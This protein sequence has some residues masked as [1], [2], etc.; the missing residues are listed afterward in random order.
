MSDQLQINIGADTKGLET[1]LQKAVTAIDNFD[2]EVQSSAKDLQKFSQYLPNIAVPPNTFKAA[3][4]GLKGLGSAV[5]AAGDKLKNLPSTTDK[6]KIALGNL[7]RVASDLPFGFIAISNNL[8]PLIQSIGQ[9]DASA[10]GKLG[11]TLKALG[12]ALAGPAGIA[13]AFSVVSSAIT[14]AVQKYGTLGNAINAIFGRQDA[15]VKQTQ[16][17][18]KSYEKFNQQLRTTEEIQGAAAGSTAGE[19]A[20]V[21]ALAKIVQDQ[22]KTYSERNTALKELQ[23]INKTYFGDI[24]LEKGKLDKLTTS[25]E[26]YTQATIQSAITKAFESE[27]GAT[28]V[29]LDRQQRV[30][31]KLRPAYEAT[32]AAIRGTSKALPGLA[33][34][35]EQFTLGNAA[36]TAGNAFKQQ[37][38]AVNAL[39]ERIKELNSGINSSVEAYNKLL[40]PQQAAAEAAKLKAEQD[41]K[42]ADAATKQA[43]AQGVVNTKLREYNDLVARQEKFKARLQTVDFVPPELP[44]IT[45]P[46]K[47]SA[48]VPQSTLDSFNA[49]AEEQRKALD[50]NTLQ[51]YAGIFSDTLAPAIDAA[52]GALANGTSAIDAIKNS[53]KGLLAQLAANAAKALLFKAALSFIPGLG[54]AGAIG[55]GGI[56]QSLL[57][58]NLLGGIGGAAAPR[59]TGTSALSGGLQL[60]GQVVFT[61]RGTDLVGVLNSSNARIGRVG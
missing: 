5:N 49:F 38:T 26:A 45:I 61:Q 33:Q 60:A 11:P 30:L 32:S 27:I 8:D 44:E 52:F 35:Q 57:G 10:K 47:I 19:A 55:G 14:F 24:D 51:L 18:A 9:L 54:T 48:I 12:S 58:G 17:A 31:E 4:D 43:A 59:F 2:K 41:K 36:V 1:G 20:K 42:A 13:L 22:T 23:S 28:T 46:A 50:T 25:V 6:A 39:K 37:E 40:A 53:L 29:E 56:L 7:G 3:E 16:D 21:Q 15:L 34:A